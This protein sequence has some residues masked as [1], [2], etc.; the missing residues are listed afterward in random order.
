ML[1]FRFVLIA[2]ALLAAAP[3]F[4]NAQTPDAAT[5]SAT[6]NSKATAVP[7]RIGTIYSAEISR[8]KPEFSE[9]SPFDQPTVD[10]PVW[11]EL[12]VRIDNER[13]ISRFDYELIG[14]RTTPYPCFAVAEKNDLYSVNPDNWIIKKTNG[15]NYYRLL[16]PVDQAELSGAKD[17]LGM[18]L[19]MKLFDTQLPPTEFKVRVMPEANG[20]TGT[21]I[22]PKGI[23]NTPFSELP[24]DIQIRSARRR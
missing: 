20:F 1:R 10:N 17:L 24:Y 16:F 6:S 23:C 8:L 13:S 21:S 18:T 12:V 5:T 14:R 15:A 19:K 11:V 9:E 3:L 4:I 22:P 7:F 2:A